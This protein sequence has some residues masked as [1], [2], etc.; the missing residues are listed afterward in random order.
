[1]RL[2]SPG[3]DKVA[4]ARSATPAATE[5]GL[6]LD[7][8]FIDRASGAIRARSAVHLGDTFVTQLLPYFDQYA[9]S[10]RVWAPDSRATALP[11]IA[12]DGTTGLVVIQSDG[13]G[14]RRFADGDIGFWSP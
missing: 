11:L 10:H 5:P 13:S 12:E 4:L 8:L 9:L 3:D 6:T 7:L 1:M 14:A 2:P